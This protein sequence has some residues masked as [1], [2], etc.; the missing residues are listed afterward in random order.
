MHD[1]DLSTVLTGRRLSSIISSKKLPT[2]CENY[3]TVNIEKS[4]LL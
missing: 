2:F 4:D 3:V 1:Q